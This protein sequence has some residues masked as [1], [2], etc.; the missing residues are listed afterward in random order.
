MTF[1]M[2]SDAGSLTWDDGVWSGDQ[3]LIDMIESQVR[4]GTPIT[5]VPTGPG[6]RSANT[7]DWVALYTAKSVVDSI[8]LNA[9]WSGEPLIPADHFDIP[10]DAYP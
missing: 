5:T 9:E 2:T 3:W 6:V 10:D 8:G 7:P 1:S 4:A